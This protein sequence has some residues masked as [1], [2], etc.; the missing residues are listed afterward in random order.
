[1]FFH[2]NPIGRERLPPFSFL[3][4]F[5]K[6]FLCYAHSRYK[7]FIHNNQ[8]L[9]GIGFDFSED[10]L[11]VGCLIKV[12]GL[13]ILVT[14]TFEGMI[15]G[16]EIWIIGGIIDPMD[17]LIIGR[18]FGPIFTEYD[19]IAGKHYYIPY[20]G[21]ALRYFAAYFEVLWGGTN[22]TAGKV[23]MWF[24]PNNEGSS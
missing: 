16:C 9:G 13:N 19:L 4:H 3:S 14:E 1:M 7:K 21:M 15:P 24:G 6:R 20:I 22:P 18:C 5:F 11:D 12:P 10:Y 23:T 8:S 17:Y 2:L